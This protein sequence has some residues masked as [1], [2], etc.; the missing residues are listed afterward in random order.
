MGDAARID[1]E[2][3]HHPALAAKSEVLHTD[4]CVA[5]DDEAEPGAAR[6]PQAFQHVASPRGGARRPRDAAVSA[7]NTGA[8][9]AM[10]KFCLKTIP[11]IDRPAIAVLWPTVEA[12]CI[13]LDVGANVAP[14]PASSWSLP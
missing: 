5:M 14:T 2:L 3:K 7:G 6:A 11:G 9:M 13:A 1:A 4:D 8:L 12:E 10:A